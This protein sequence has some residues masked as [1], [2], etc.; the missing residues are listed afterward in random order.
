MNGASTQAIA[1]GAGLS[2]AQLHYYIEL[3]RRLRKA[4]GKGTPG[5]WLPQV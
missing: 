3:G 2:K 5:S 4:R 1:D